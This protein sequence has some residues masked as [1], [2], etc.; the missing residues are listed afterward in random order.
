MDQ[1]NTALN[2]NLNLLVVIQLNLALAFAM[3]VLL[4]LIDEFSAPSKPHP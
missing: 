3:L 4:G 1:I 2:T